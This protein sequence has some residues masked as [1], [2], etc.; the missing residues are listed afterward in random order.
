[1]KR[2]Y[3]YYL[4]ILIIVTA[5]AFLRHNHTVK[6]DARFLRD[7]EIVSEL[8]E[9]MATH[10]PQGF[11]S[12]FPWND[13]RNPNL[14]VTQKNVLD[15][16]R[17]GHSWEGDSFR[18]AVYR[19]TKADVGETNQMFNAAALLK[20]YFG[21]LERSGFTS[22]EKGYSTTAATDSTEVA[23]K[24]WYNWNRTLI[25]QGQIVK[26]RASGEIIASLSYWG[27]LNYHPR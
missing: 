4:A 11:E 22:G 10:A 15:T 8:S 14:S 19:P 16:V 17:S 24:Y 26:D 20:N 21:D 13:V 3:R 18:Q 2:I 23:R 1:M 7:Y 6:T 25:V 9:R 5:A 12:A 27:T